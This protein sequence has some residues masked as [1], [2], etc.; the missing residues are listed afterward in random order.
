MY[1]LHI[2]SEFA[3]LAKVG[4]LAD[5]IYGL[6]KEQTALG[7]KVEVILPKYDLIKYALLENFSLE[8]CHLW[9]FENASS[10]HNSVW[11]GFVQ[12]IKVY[13]IEP[14]HN[15]YY[16]NR[17]H[18]YGSKD[19]ADRFLYFC[20]TCVEFLFSQE[21]QP[22]II[23]LHDWLTAP[24]AYMLKKIS[25][26]PTCGGTV[27]TIHNVEHQG[28]CSYQNLTKL[29]FQKD[30]FLSKEKFQDPCN[31]SLIN[32][33]KGGIVYCDAFTTVSPTY[34]KEIKTPAYGFNL[35]EVIVQFDS[36]FSGILNGIDLQIWNPSKDPNLP[37]PYP[38]N[39]TFIDTLLKKKEANRSSLFKT[40]Q[41]ASHSGPFFICIC[42]LVKQKGLERILQAIEYVLEQKG[43][44]ALL[45]SHPDKDFEKTIQ[46]LKQR[47]HPYLYIHLTFDEPLSHLLYASADAIL[48]P[49]LYEP[50][51]LT[52][53]I[54]MRYGTLP[55]V[56]KIGGLA[57]TVF[58]AND[59][60]IPFHA[61]NG[62]A[63]EKEDPIS[64]ERTLKKVFYCFQHERKKWNRLIQN[65]LTK[66][67]G[68]EKPASLYQKIYQ[69]IIRTNCQHVA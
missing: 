68:W 4:G 58:D 1:I 42:R 28:K 9:S 15:Q 32:L 45:G 16:F 48:I 22:H 2:A 41:L 67:F 49:S 50:C 13:M 12:G 5:V 29:G 8:V 39:S 57:D 26:T 20:R 34:A 47:Y 44:F 14:H 11:T 30:D 56:H 61:R 21:K 63:F 33:L 6:A 10:F 37:Y 7:H 66:N 3:P 38:T 27:L 53:M 17:G 24:I 31:P 35:Q 19:D 40:L 23:H 59:P 54:A 55:I 69:N 36:K 51:G 43:T 25:P 60:N 62:F 65:G 64:L 18:I 52:Q 46:Q